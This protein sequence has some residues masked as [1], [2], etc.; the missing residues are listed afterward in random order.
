MRYILSLDQGTA[1]SRAILFDEKQNVV[2]SAQ[3]EF[4]QIFPREGWVEQDPMEIYSS[5]YA[6][7]MEA[8]AKSG[9]DVR[10][11]AAVGI[12]NQR[13][14]TVVWDKQTGRPVCNAIVW[15]C[16]RT[17]DIVDE[18]VR[19]GHDTYIRETT[20]LVPDAYFSGPKITWILNNVAGAR[21]RAER[22]ELLFGTVDTWL[23]WKLTNGR[24][25]MTDRTN[26]SRT[27]LYNIRTLEWDDT[28]LR[29][30]DIPRAMLPKVRESSFIY[31]HVPLQD[32][33]VPIA[34]SRG[35]AGGAL[36]TDLLR[37]GRGQ[38]HIRHRLLPADEHGPGA[39]FQ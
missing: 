23:I 24:V 12:A 17:S 3:R 1:S 22:G 28:L 11:I 4:A 16:R 36:R 6:V 9:V 29:L 26:A 13:E 35:P 30:M 5:Q 38:K 20:G 37:K 34:A 25:H 19:G 39:G 27:M 14:T 31:G 21:E 10:D 8:V 32:V 33:F 2:G 7:L 15:Q 18:L